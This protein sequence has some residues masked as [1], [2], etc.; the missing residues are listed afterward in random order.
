MS[1]RDVQVLLVEDDEVAAMAV[2]RAFK[3]ADLSNHVTVARDGVE[4]LDIL[5]G[6]DEAEPFERP[7]IILLDLNLPRMS[8]HEFLD[9][10]REDA[11]LRDSVVFVMTTSDDATDKLQAYSRFVAGYI[12]KI[13]GEE[14][15]RDLTDLL[16]PF[17]RVVD[18]PD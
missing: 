1:R 13:P 16:E 17:W 8:G 4:A 11:R 14:Q 15:Y 6:G 18:L 2:R 3:K 10:L 5:R 9:E 7:Y 12:R